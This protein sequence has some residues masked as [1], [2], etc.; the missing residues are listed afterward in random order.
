MRRRQFF[1]L[2]DIAAN[3][4]RGKKAPAISPVAL[5]AVKRI[6]VL[7]DIERDIN[8]LSAEERLR[9]A[10]GTERAACGRAGSLAARRACPPVA[11]GLRRQADRLHAQALGPALPASST[12]AGSASPTTRPSAR[13]AA[14]PWDASRGC[15]PVPIAAPT[16]PRPWHTL[17][18][19]AKL[20]DVDPLAWLADVLARIADTPQSRLPELLPWEWKKPSLQAAA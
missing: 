9:V 15:S 10:A 7:F 8:G 16:A 5:E 11:L 12:T 17:I 1:E 4:R 18:M 6:D 3:A 19:T 13:C 2:A 20:N 14:L